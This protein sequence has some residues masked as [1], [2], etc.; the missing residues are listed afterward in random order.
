MDRLLEGKRVLL[1]VTGG[2]AAYKSCELA[3]RL[4]RLGAEIQV[5][6]SEAA[7]RFVTPLT[8][9]ALTQRPVLTD[10]F[11]PEA[12]SRA[13]V[14]VELGRWPDLVLI[15]PATY[16]FIGKLA[17][18]LADDALSAL[19]AAA[20]APVVLC[21]AMNH[22]M[23]AKPALAENLNRLRQW[24]YRIVGPE[25]GEL[26]EGEIGWGRLAEVET[27]LDA[28]E[29]ELLRHDA[30]HGR[31]VLVTAGPTQEPVDPV[32]FITNRSSGRMGYALAQAALWAG[33]EVTLV[34]GPTPLQPPRGVGFVSVRT[35]AE[36]AEAVERHWPQTE[37]LFMAAAVSDYRPSQVAEHKLKK[38]EGPTLRLDLEKTPDILAW[39]GQNKGAR[40]LVGFAVETENELANAMEKLRRKNLDLIVVNN[41]LE[42]GAGFET[43]TNRVTILDAEGHLDDWPLLSKLEVARRL[44]FRVG[45]LWQQ[46]HP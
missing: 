37:I 4:I 23:Y 27:I 30:L 17:C 5:V 2:I 15:A 21:P 25:R 20:E 42:P 34:S 24:G 9:E 8:F 41:P 1:G 39:A 11:R 29:Y 43:D 12:G 38:G 13:T 14:H 44:V 45:Q 19:V 22:A 10:L 31:R 33:A 36:M 26:A 7:T 32:R 40:I 3:R 46:R 18:G 28:V 35:A 6:M 16:D